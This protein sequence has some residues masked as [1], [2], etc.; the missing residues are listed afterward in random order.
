MN[1][2]KECETELKELAFNS[3]KNYLERKES[4]ISS[5]SPINEALREKLGC[6]VSL[7]KEGHLRGC[8]GTFYAAKPLFENIINMAIAAATED[9]RFKSVTLPELEKIDIEISVLSPRI[10]VEDVKNIVIGTHGLYITRGFNSG[11]LLPQVATEY[12]WSVEEFLEHTCNKAGLNK[13][14]W[15]KEGTKIEFFT[16]QVF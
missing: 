14:D 12:N 3:I 5:Y 8:I 1:L 16:A 9:T 15:K 11:V 7:H 2:S 13:N 6:F 4:L 10:V